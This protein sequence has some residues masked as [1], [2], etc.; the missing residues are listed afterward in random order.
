M[1]ML[2]GFWLGALGTAWLAWGCMD[3][4]PAS[5]SGADAGGSAAQTDG[6]PET[7]GATHGD[8]HEAGTGGQ[9]STDGDRATGG[10]AAQLGGA[11]ASGSDAC[12]RACSAEFETCTAGV[13]RATEEVRAQ[14]VMVHLPGGS[15]LMGDD[16]TSHSAPVHARTVD[17]FW[18]DQ[19]EVTAGAYDLCV[20]AGGC[21]PADLAG[22]GVN[23]G[24]P[25]YADY[26]VNHVTL[27][28]AEA[29]CA[30]LGKRLPTEVEWEY[31]A[32]GRQALTYPWGEGEPAA[33]LRGIAA[34]LEFDLEADVEHGCA[35]GQ[36]PENAN[37]IQDLGGSVVEFT[38]S[39]FCPYDAVTES[40]Y[41]SGCASEL[42]VLRDAGFTSPSVDLAKVS[43]RQ[44]VALD[45]KHQA[46]GFRCAA[47]SEG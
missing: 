6:A 42:H 12:A 8:G 45:T 4:T 18:L 19:T 24:A 26:P 22:L 36:L 11:G 15:F 41:V 14:T 1:A 37:G 9:L 32:G 38:S 20:L 2:R 3:R 16:E 21:T 40:G 28:Q 29:Y 5:D 7:G 13:C 35:V 25:E 34:S 43:T 33:C 44:S 47:S 46:L 10:R 30:W 17:A 27:T 23:S 31:A 39:R